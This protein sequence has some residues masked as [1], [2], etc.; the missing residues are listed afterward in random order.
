MITLSIEMLVKAMSI[1]KGLEELVIETIEMLGIKDGDFR[2]VG[3]KKVRG[4][5]Q[6]SGVR[7]IKPLPRTCSL[8]LKVQIAGKDSNHACILVF[9]P[10]YK[11]EQ[12]RKFADVLAGNKGRTDI[13]GDNL[14]DDNN[15]GK[16]PAGDGP[17]VQPENP[18][19]IESQQDT[20][21]RLKGL[22]PEWI[23]LIVSDI[24]DKH[25]TG[26]TSKDALF[27]TIKGM[28]LDYP[29][30]NLVDKFIEDG[31]LEVNPGNPTESSRLTASACLLI[32]RVATRSKEEDEIL[33]QIKELR[34]VKASYDE[35]MQ[36][37]KTATAELELLR[38]QDKLLD[39]EL[40]RITD[41]LNTNR[42]N[43]CQKQEEISLK[44][45]Q[46]TP[47]MFEISQS[48]GVLSLGGA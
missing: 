44:Q 27:E 15:A 43:I 35:I 42:E 33:R 24:F 13:K 1:P 8:E 41:L 34:G 37:I 29:P 18:G 45:N 16:P 19:K 30:Q 39:E 3:V 20:R 36:G 25:A 47:Q 4:V 23:T 21:L 22:T 7:F 11:G 48:L 46:I 2:L 32:G 12:L 14:P 26:Y 17:Y 28:E 6:N 5:N 38:E 40:S 9:P 10:M 31:Y